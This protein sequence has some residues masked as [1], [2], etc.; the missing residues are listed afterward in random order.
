MVGNALVL[1]AVLDAVIPTT[2]IVPSVSIATSPMKRLGIE[3]PRIE[4]ER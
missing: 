1:V 2:A 4:A 3:R